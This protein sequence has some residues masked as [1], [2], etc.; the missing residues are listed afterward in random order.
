M[1]LISQVNLTIL[2]IYTQL[3]YS[4]NKLSHLAAMVQ[5]KDLPDISR[6]VRRSDQLPIHNTVHLVVGEESVEVSILG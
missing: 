2:S 1:E 6:F 5:M 3:S 4:L